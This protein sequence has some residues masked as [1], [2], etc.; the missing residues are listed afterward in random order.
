MRGTRARPI[1]GAL[2]AFGLGTTRPTSTD[3]SGSMPDRDDLLQLGYEVPIHI[4]AR[5]NIDTHQLGYGHGL[6][7]FIGVAS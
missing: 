2:G 1:M 6:G 5:S 4:T 7:V 3:A